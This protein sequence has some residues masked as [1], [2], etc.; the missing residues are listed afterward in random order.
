[1]AGLFSYSLHLDYN[2]FDV[3]MTWVKC[4][5]AGLQLLYNIPQANM[6]WPFASISTIL[7][8]L[9]L[10]KNVWVS[11]WVA[12]TLLCRAT[13]G[14]IHTG[15]FYQ[16]T[17]QLSNLRKASAQNVA[18]LFGYSLHLTYKLIFMHQWPE[19]CW[20]TATITVQHPS[21]QHSLTFCFNNN[22][23]NI[24]VLSVHICDG[25]KVLN[26]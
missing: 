7:L 19:F 5:F 25:H 9:P 22:N 11:S 16:A 3:S 14:H 23:N 21:S 8:P 13:Y 12:H 24:R 4:F 26:S 6:C 18:E 17:L 1:M 10:R 2:V 20:I 15:P